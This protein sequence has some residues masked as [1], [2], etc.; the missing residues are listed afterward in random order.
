MRKKYSRFN[1][2]RALA[3]FLM[4]LLLV[5]SLA[6]FP[7]ILDP[8]PPIFLLLWLSSIPIFVLF[9]FIFLAVFVWQEKVP[10]EEEEH[11]G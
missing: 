11:R 5:S 10:G 3:T 8:Q 1:D 9:Y 6:M 7:F 4:I 2:N